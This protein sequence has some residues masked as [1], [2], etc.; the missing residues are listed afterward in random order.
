MKLS[1]LCTALAGTVLAL[2]AAPSYAAA[3]DSLT[4]VAAPYV[5]V[6]TI[7]ATFND[8]SGG[9]ADVG[10]GETDIM[11]A[12]DS[13]FLGHLETQGDNWGVYGDMLFIG[14]ADDRN[15]TLVS[16]DAELDAGIY[17]LAAVWS[18]GD[19]RY[20]GFE[21]YAG[22]RYIALDL[23][24]DFDPV[25]PALSS[26][27]ADFDQN[28]TDFLIGARYS[29]PLAEKWAFTA[30]ADASFGDTEGTWNI[31]G[32]FSRQMGPGALVFGYRY[33]DGEVQPNE[34]TLDIELYGPEIGY[35]FVW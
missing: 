28:F 24:L 6:P 34:N 30:R 20:R 2:C 11:D 18:P 29:V 7:N 31:S 9:N 21:G 25:N 22:V 12:L 15:G 33:F 23:Q 27:N 13:G 10:E 4:W 8:R 14:F 32:V 26:R 35:A 5:W 16:T 3:N 1:A 19:D 17:D